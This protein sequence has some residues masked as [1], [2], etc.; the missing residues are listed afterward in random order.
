MRLPC[1][2][3]RMQIWCVC[4]GCVAVIWDSSIRDIAWAA[5]AISLLLSIQEINNMKRTV[6]NHL[7]HEL[8]KFKRKL[9]IFVS[10]SGFMSPILGDYRWAHWNLHSLTHA[11]EAVTLARWNILRSFP[12]PVLEH[13]H[14]TMK[15]CCMLILCTVEHYIWIRYHFPRW[16]H[17]RK[18]FSNT[19]LLSQR[20]STASNKS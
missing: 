4:E 16:T 20:C 3:E 6:W 10:P 7:L 11:Q 14:V 8:P 2:A 19:I 9:T 15:R 13:M 18:A 1:Y 5:H 12:L 17:N